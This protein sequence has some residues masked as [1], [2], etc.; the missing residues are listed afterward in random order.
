[1]TRSFANIIGDWDILADVRIRQ[2]KSGKDLSYSHFLIPNIISLVS[3][4]DRIIDIGCGVGAGTASLSKSGLDVIGIDPSEKSIEL[5]RKNFPN[6]TY[7]LSSAENYIPNHKFDAA[8]LNMVLTNICDLE[9]FLSSVKQLIIQSGRVIIS[10]C[11][12]VFWPVYKNLTVV[13]GYNYS[14]VKYFDLPFTVTNDLEPTTQ[15]SLYI[16]RPIEE[17][18]RCFKATGFEIDFISEPMPDRELEKKYV[19]TWK[20]PRFM[21]IQLSLST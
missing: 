2:I 1:M 18:V 9:E 4:S 19:T 5:A 16:H 3:Y 13:N 21:F 8:I 15:T 6:S 14:E 12:P 11:H 20:F 17:Y 7:M 10:I